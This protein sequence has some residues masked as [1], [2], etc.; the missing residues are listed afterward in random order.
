MP[1]APFQ[2]ISI[3]QCWRFQFP[4][5][6]SILKDPPG[7]FLVCFDYFRLHFIRYPR[8][9]RR[10]RRQTQSRLDIVQDRSGSFRIFQD[11]S[12]SS[13]IAQA[14]FSSSNQSTI[15]LINRERGREREM[16][17]ILIRD[18]SGSLSGHPSRNERAISSC[19]VYSHWKK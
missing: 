7:S 17:P 14:S 4:T 3:A 19:P 16:N 13:G 8:H 18:L 11:H 12:G 5:P 2:S 9:L 10:F 1:Y 6:V 15:D